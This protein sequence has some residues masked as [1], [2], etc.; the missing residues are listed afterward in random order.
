MKLRESLTCFVLG[1]IGYGALE[2]MTRGR[3]HWS[4]LLT[5]GACMTG[6]Y[7]LNKKRRH[8]P[9]L[10]TCAL[11]AGLITTAEYAVGCYVNIKKQWHVWDYSR[12]PLNVRGQICL[13]YT[14]LWFLLCLPLAPLSHGLESCLC[15]E[16]KAGSRA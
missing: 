8:K 11:C 14:C 16:Q 9:V 7:A 1:G 6:V 4:M 2:L 3:T 5:G 12:M 13:P 15:S 10:S